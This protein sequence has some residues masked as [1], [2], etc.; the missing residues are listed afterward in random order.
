MYRGLAASLLFASVALAQEEGDDVPE[1]AK[2]QIRLQFGGQVPKA[3]KE[4]GDHD[5][6]EPVTNEPPPPKKRS[7]RKA[8]SPEKAKAAPERAKATESEPESPAPSSHRKTTLP[9]PEEEAEEA[10]QPK[11]R[12]KQ[13]HPPTPPP[14]ENQEAEEAP[15]HKAA[16]PPPPPPEE[17]PEARTPKEEQGPDRTRYRESE[18]RS[19]TAG[20]ED[21]VRDGDK[22]KDK[23]GKSSEPSTPKTLTVGVGGAYVGLFGI[24]G[25][26]VSG[27]ATSD[28]IAYGANAAAR[29]A[30]DLPFI[31]SSDIRIGIHAALPGWIALQAIVAVRQDLATLGPIVF[32][33]RGGAGLEIFLGLGSDATVIAPGIVGE[34]EMGAEIELGSSGKAYFGI[35]GEVDARYAVPLGLGFGVGVT[36]R[37]RFVF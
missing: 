16:R 36:L 14:E 34:G 18:E 24:K 12:P 21:D 28:W 19:G 27:T 4:E 37:G 30:L 17:E 11:P 22:D 7:K 26:A 9:S 13:A 20:R 15:V 35:V 32:F 5:V 33:G 31:G 8:K 3:K 23:E 29:L 6:G 1:S 2:Q 25:F 10:R